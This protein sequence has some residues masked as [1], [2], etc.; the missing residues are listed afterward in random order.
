MASTIFVRFEFSHMNFILVQ[1]H[2]QRDHELFLLT[3][4]HTHVHSLKVIVQQVSR[5]QNY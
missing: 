5:R 2:H 3:V 4:V 1:G